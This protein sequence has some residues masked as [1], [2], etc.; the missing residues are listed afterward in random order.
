MPAKPSA[1]IPHHFSPIQAP[2]VNRQMK[3]QLQDIITGKQHLNF[4]NFTKKER[5]NFPVENGYHIDFIKTTH[6]LT[7]KFR[8]D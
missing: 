7:G 4:V 6:Y 1:S 2:R 5:L 3:H 8:A